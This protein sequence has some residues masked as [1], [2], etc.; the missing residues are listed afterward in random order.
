MMLAPLLRNVCM[1]VY[2]CRHIESFIVYMSYT[3]IYFWYIC[4]CVYTYVYVCVCKGK[5]GTLFGYLRARDAFC[6]LFPRCR[7]CAPCRPVTVL[8]TSPPDLYPLSQRRLMVNI[9]VYVCTYMQLY[10]YVYLY[11]Y[12]QIYIN[13]IC[14]YLYIQCAM[15]NQS[16]S[17]SRRLLTFTLYLNDDSW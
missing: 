4:V 7:I 16:R 17:S 15:T 10:M 6:N 9:H 8:V 13:F 11:I 3:Y 1:C 5:S 12:I 2:I 14:I